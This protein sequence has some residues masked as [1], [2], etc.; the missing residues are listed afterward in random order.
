LPSCGEA[1]AIFWGYT[2]GYPGK[3]LRD[4]MDF[5]A[6]GALALSGHVAYLYNPGA[7]QGFLASLFGKLPYHLW[8]YPPSYL[9]LAAGFDWLSPWRAVFA[10][11]VWSL[12][13]FAAVLR[14]AGKSWW[15]TAAMLAAPAN[16]ESLLEHQNATLMTTLIG[17]GLLLMRANP[18]LAGILIGVA[19]IKPQL[20]LVLP[21]NLVRRSVGA[22]AYACLAAVLLVV[23]SLHTF[24]AAAWAG[25]W[26]FTRPAM[27]AVLLTGKP[28]E[29]AGGLLSV[30]ATFRFLGTNPALAVQ[31]TVTLAAI[32]GAALTRSTPVLLILSALASPYL[33]DYDLLGAALAVALMFEQRQRAGFAPG[34][35]FLF[36]IAWFGPGLLPWAAQFAHLTPVVLALLLASAMRS[37]GLAECDSSQVQPGSP[38]LS[39]GPSPIPAPPASTA[40]G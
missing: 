32:V 15:F 24:G 1:Y 11:D 2:H 9:L 37:G 39:A 17:G 40:P 29:F 30:F 31:F 3:A 38:A 16:I 14:M 18:R 34:E 27:S 10:F 26:H 33:H 12:A 36:F 22:F 5:W 19:S 35:S 28:P 25:F 7:Y 23:L 13:L 4:G 6:G 21:L 20:G 8:S